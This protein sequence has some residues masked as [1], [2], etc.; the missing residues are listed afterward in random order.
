MLWRVDLATVT[1]CEPDMKAEKVLGF[2]V[3][4]SFLM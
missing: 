1:E 3:A 2:E 4:R